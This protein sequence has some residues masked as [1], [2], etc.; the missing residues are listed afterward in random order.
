V[1]EGTP[2]G[3]PRTYAYSKRILYIDQDFFGPGLQDIY[4]QHGELWKSMLNCGYYTT[5]PYDGYPTKRLPGA[6]YNYTDEWLFVP[7]F[8]FLDVQKG[9][10][11]AGEAPPGSRKPSEWKTEWYFNEPVSVNAPDV[12]SPSA[13]N[14]GT[15]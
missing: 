14:R 1:I 6:N 4:D 5:K 13:L 11:T 2:T 15:R 3:Y 9:L 12:F 8:V 10:A 7:N